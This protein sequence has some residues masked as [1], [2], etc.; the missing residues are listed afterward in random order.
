MRPDHKKRLRAAHGLPGG[1]SGLGFEADE[2][3]APAGDIGSDMPLGRDRIAGL[4]VTRPREL[5]LGMQ[6]PDKIHGGIG[7]TEK[8]RGGRAQRIDGGE[9]GRHAGLRVG[10][11]GLRECGRA[12]GLDMKAHRR[13]GS[14]RDPGR[15]GSYVAA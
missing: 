13:V 12:L 5:L 8:L 4:G 3:H 15:A 2:A 6:Q 7:V 1:I 14:S 9:G 10:A 11:D